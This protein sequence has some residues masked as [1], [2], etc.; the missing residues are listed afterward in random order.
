LG[1]A[2]YTVRAKVPPARNRGG[3]FSKDDF[4][5]D[6][7]PGHATCP[8]GNTAPITPARRGGGQATFRR[9]CRSCPLRAQCTTAKAGRSIVIHPREATLQAA[10]AAQADPA[11]RAAYRATRPTAERKIAHFTR[12]VWGGRK[13]RCRGTARLLTDVLTRAAVVNLARLAAL[14][15]RHAPAGWAVAHS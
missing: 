2:G 13:A 8:A 9:F 7:G 14:G 10:R 5:I 15:L 6:L 12:R 11:W 1:Q 3:R 4:D